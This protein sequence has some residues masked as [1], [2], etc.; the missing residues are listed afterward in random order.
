MNSRMQHAHVMHKRICTLLLSA[1]ESLQQNL[2]L[3]LTKLRGVTLKLGKC[4]SFKKARSYQLYRF[5]ENTANVW[6][7]RKVSAD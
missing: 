6:F 7:K 4:K 2:A 1:H 3:H 5:L